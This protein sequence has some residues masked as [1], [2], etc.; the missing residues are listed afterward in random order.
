M[1]P[2]AAQNFQGT[3]CVQICELREAR[4]E[5][6]CQGFTLSKSVEQL[7]RDREVLSKKLKVIEQAYK[8]RAAKC[9]ISHLPL[10]AQVSVYAKPAL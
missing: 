1:R 9:S 5:E 6:E 10:L 3:A 7:K 2:I 4:V 8:V